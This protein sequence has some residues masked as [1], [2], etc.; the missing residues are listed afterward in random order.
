MKLNNFLMSQKANGQN[1]MDT[2]CSLSVTE[3]QCRPLARPRLTST[4]PRY[5]RFSNVDARNF[6]LFRTVLL[7]GVHSKR[8]GSRLHVRKNRQ[9]IH[10]LINPETSG[11]STA[12]C[13]D[14]LEQ[15]AIKADTYSAD[16][17]PPVPFFRGNE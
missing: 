4:A 8:P 15:T 17:P 2:L 3:W 13:T 1:R 11:P 12:G 9:F 10:T 14:L 16:S 7:T 5:L 6:F